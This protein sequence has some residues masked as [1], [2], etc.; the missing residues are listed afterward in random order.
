MVEG[1]GAVDVSLVMDGETCCVF[2]GGVAEVHVTGAVRHI[3]DGVVGERVALV[4]EVEDAT[5]AG[6]A[7]GRGV[8]CVAVGCAGLGGEARAAVLEVDENPVVTRFTHPEA[9]LRAVRALAVTSR[10]DP[11]PPHA[12]VARGRGCAVVIA[13]GGGDVR[14]RL[15]GRLQLLVVDVGGRAEEE[16]AVGADLRVDEV[17]DAVVAHALGE[18][19]RR[20]SGVASVDGAA[21]VVAAPSS[22]TSRQLPLRLRRH[23]SRHRAQATKPAANSSAAVTRRRAG[24]TRRRY[25]QRRARHIG[26]IPLR[27]LRP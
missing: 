5:G 4:G 7:L 25:D 22:S 23:R 26:E 16:V 18:L 8:V 19:E 17:L 3:H 21:S 12:D 10:H 1:S 2:G 27:S 14:A 20:E 15:V 13:K 11:F 9:E 6:R 24:I